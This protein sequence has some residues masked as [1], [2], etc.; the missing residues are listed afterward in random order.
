ML[1]GWLGRVV[2]VL[3]LRT[4]TLAGVKG[5]A[6]PV[7]TGAAALLL[8]VVLVAG[9]GGDSSEEAVIAPQ[10]IEETGSIETGDLR[11]PKHSDL[12]YDAFTFEAER[13]ERVRVEV[14]AQG[15]VPLL[16]LVEVSTGAPL[17][18]WEAAYSDSDALEYTIAGAGAYEAR[19]YAIDKG[20]GT[21]TVTI[22]VD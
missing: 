11:D 18:E 6:A 14:T 21:Y 20:T 10:V 16:K 5:K 19:V 9:C 8:L 4:P 7:L 17:A 13:Y 15:F 12:A 22:Q 1:Q 2:T 3:R